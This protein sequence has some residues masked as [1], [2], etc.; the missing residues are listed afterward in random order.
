MISIWIRFSR[1]V[2]IKILKDHPDARVEFPDDETLATITAA[3]TDKYPELEELGETVW[4]AM[5]G[6]KTLIQS[7]GDDLTQNKF[8]NGWKNAHY[9]NSLFLFSAD[10]KVRA[11]VFN[12]PGVVHD[13]TMAEWGGVYEKVEELFQSCR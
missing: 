13:S 8:H 2:V 5:D 3:I 1:R 10:G 6:L 12:V 7:S 4:A 9:V 11:V